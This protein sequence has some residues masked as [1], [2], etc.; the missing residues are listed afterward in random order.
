MVA[1]GKFGFVQIHTGV[2]KVVPRALEGFLH[3]FVDLDVAEMLCD[4]GGRRTLAEA[5]RDV[6][7]VA[8]RAG[9]M[10]LEDI[11]CEVG[12][13]AAADGA[14]EVRKGNR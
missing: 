1:E 5:I 4:V 9:L 7:D 6:R 13:F 8:E 11:G 2:A 3:V 10:A 14:E 12:V